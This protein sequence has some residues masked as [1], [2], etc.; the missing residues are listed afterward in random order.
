MDSKM[1]SPMWRQSLSV[2]RRTIARHA[3]LIWMVFLAA[4]GLFFVWR[5]HGEVAQVGHAARQMQFRWLVPIIL[6]HLSTVIIAGFSYRTI[7]RRLGHR[8]TWGDCSRLHLQRHVVGTITPLG[9]PASIYVLIRGLGQRGICS[10]DAVLLAT[11]RSAVGNIAFVLLLIPALALQ[12]PNGI[13]L[14]GVAILVMLLALVVS[15]LWTLLHGGQLPERVSRMLPSRVVA[16]T[17]T[18]RAHEIRARDLAAP[19]GLAF[20]GNVAGAASVYFCLRGLGY[21]AGVATGLVG[22]AIG[23]LFQI[24][25][26]VFQ[27]IGVVEVTMALAIQQQ[28]I[29][30]AGAAA[31]TLMYRVGDVWLLLAVGVLVQACGHHRTRWAVE[32]TLPIAAGATGILFLLAAPHGSFTS[33]LMLSRWSLPYLSVVVTVVTLLSAIAL[34]GTSAGFLRGRPLAQVVPVTL[35]I[36]ALPVVALAGAGV[37]LVLPLLT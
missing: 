3:V 11:I 9:G 26:P 33:D 5:Q 37:P 17:N 19:F 36:A 31:T 10:T 18:I 8:V 12:R 35:M 15:L 7:L 6:A 28:G 30:A 1:L 14:G 24:V 13:V 29:P 23:N 27:G 25:A 22:Y 2:L 16:F 4:M 32:R 34:I 21:S 20:A